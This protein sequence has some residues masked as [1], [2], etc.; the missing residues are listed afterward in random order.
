MLSTKLN[1]FCSILPVI[2]IT[3][4]AGKWVKSNPDAMDYSSSVTACQKISSEKF[5][6]KNEVA[7]GTDFEMRYRQCNDKSKCDGKDYKY[8]EEP[9]TKSYAMD[10]NK[11]S[12]KDAFLD[13][14]NVNG[15]EKKYF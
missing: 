3:G 12:R 4:C 7:Q 10:V 15:W 9:V 5:P 13:C 8:V 6:V 2:L 1:K 11:N 14:M